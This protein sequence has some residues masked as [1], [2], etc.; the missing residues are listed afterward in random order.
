MDLRREAECA[1]DLVA[2][3]G[4][5]ARSMQSGVTAR[6][7]GGGEGPVTEADLQAEKILLAGILRHFPEDAIVSEETLNAGVPAGRERIWC[8]DPID[9]TREY[10]DGLP[11][12]ACM[13]GLLVGGLPAAGAIS[14]PGEGRV[15]W[16]WSGGGAFLDGTPTTLAPSRI[17]RRITN[18]AITTSAEPA[19][20]P[21]TAS[22][23]P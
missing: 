5:L 15:L 2:E 23:S 7:K 13:V 22:R 14:L 4:D 9:G 18:H 11:E 12:Y 1:R 8:I 16:G 3:A 21:A 20:Q 17:P 10:V 6:D 19:S